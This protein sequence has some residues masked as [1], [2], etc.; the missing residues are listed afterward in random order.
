MA[1]RP[2]LRMSHG[3]IAVLVLIGSAVVALAGGWGGAERGSA[4]PQQEARSPQDRAWGSSVGFANRDRLEDHYRKHG[5]EFGSISR[6]EYLRQ[7]QALRDAPA[8]G[9]VLE[10]VRRDGVITRFDRRSGAFLAFNQDGVIRTFF[11]PNDGER[12]FHRQLDRDR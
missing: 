4:P 12:Y 8:G 10:A 7:A 9:P 3:L 1:G 6:Q 2:G 11:R 5:G